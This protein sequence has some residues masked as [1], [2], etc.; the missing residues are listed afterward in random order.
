[1]GALVG[2]VAAWFYAPCSGRQLRTW[3]ETTTNET[4][5]KSRSTLQIMLPVSKN[6]L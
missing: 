1:M 6:R 2:G 4:L 5:A 3:I